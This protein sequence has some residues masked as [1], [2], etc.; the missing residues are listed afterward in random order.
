MAV[1][2]ESGYLARVAFMM[3]AL[4]HRV[5]LQGKAV[6]P[7]ILG[8]GCT[9]PAVMGTRILETRRERLIAAATTTLVPCAA[10][11]VV[12]MGLVAVFVGLQW[13]VALYAFNLL[14]IFVLARVAYRVLPGEGV[15][16][17]MEMPLYRRPSPGLVLKRTL[18]QLKEFVVIAVPLI[19]AGSIVLEAMRLLGWLEPLSTAMAPVTVLWLGLPAVAGIVLLFGVLR[20]E[21]SLVMLA[22]LKKTA[23]FS[24]ILSPV[25]MMVFTIVVMFYVPCLATIA[26]L[27]REFG[28]SRAALLSVGEILFALVLGGL[29]FR[30]LPFIM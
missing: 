27:G 21:M 11:T 16:L 2:E 13:A 5:G 4:M 23:D 6:I 26:A 15:G 19:V 17:I 8:Y 24:R 30:L 22:S 3:D 9:V 12:I 1:L 29:A 25:Q 28:W 14:I 7:L 18:A 20:K 10:R